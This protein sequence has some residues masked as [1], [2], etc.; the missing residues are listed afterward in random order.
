MKTIFIT[1]SSAVVDMNFFLKNCREV[2][3]ELA[4]GDEILITS[5]LEEYEDIA[6]NI[7]WDENKDGKGLKLIN[8]IKK[9][10]DEYS[11]NTRKTIKDILTLD[12][13]IAF[14]YISGIDLIDYF[15][16]HYPEIKIIHLLDTEPDE[17]DIKNIRYTL[18]YHVDYFF[19]IDKDSLPALIK[20]LIN[21][22]S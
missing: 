19:T 17:D 1:S 7:G 6:W 18:Q 9:V 15:H 22:N 14:V 4:P 21:I 8:D 11:D 3:K 12:C 16:Y 10:L 13:D 2:C 20:E 5:D